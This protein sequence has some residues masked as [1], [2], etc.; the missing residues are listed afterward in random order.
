MHEFFECPSK[1]KLDQFAKDNGDS[2]HWGQWKWEKY[3]RDFYESLGDTEA[4]RKKQAQAINK[5]P[6]IGKKRLS[7]DAFGK[8]D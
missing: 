1:K 2:H 8:S 3:Y 7:E 5:S 6:T 4:E